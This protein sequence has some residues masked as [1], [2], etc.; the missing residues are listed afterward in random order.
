MKSIPHFILTTCFIFAFQFSFSQNR[1]IGNNE[2]TP[3]C[4]NIDFEFGNFTNWTGAVGYN[5]HSCSLLTIDAAGIMN[6]SLD[7]PVSACQFHTLIDTAY[8]N[9]P[10]GNFP[11]VAPDGGAYSARLGGD[12][13]N[14]Y[15]GIC[16]I[17]YQSWTYSSGEYLERTFFISTTNALLTYEY[18][19]VFHSEPT[20]AGEGPYFEAELFDQFGN[21]IS[22][23][24]DLCV[25][26][27]NSTPPPGFL[28]SQVDTNV[29]YLPWSTNAINLTAFIGQNVTI[30]FTAAG[31]IYGGHFGYAYVDAHCGTT[32][33]TGNIP[34]AGDTGTLAA[35]FLSGATYVWSGP[36]IIGSNTTQTIHVISPGT[37]TVTIHPANGCDFTLSITVTSATTLSFTA[38][39]T[40]PSC[41]S[42]NDGIIN[43]T[44]TGGSPA[45]TYNI[46][47]AA[48]NLSGNSYI[49]LPQDTYYVC[50]TD[51][52]GCT[53][54]DSVVVPPYSLSVPV[55][56]NSS[57]IFF[58]TNTV[59]GE[60]SFNLRFSPAANSHLYIYDALGRQISETTVLSKKTLIESGH[61]LPAGIY[62]YLLNTDK[63]IIAR[64]KAIIE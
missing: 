26:S 22:S 14:L 45:Y 52:N 55:I 21:A 33:I 56:N 20:S 54:C 29:F 6:G 15:E 47:P 12:H 49:N 28:V 30:R 27:I 46:S 23:C 43:F 5:T 11:G 59:T 57:A 37:Y 18:A 38:S 13:I 31:C 10:Y 63:N 62:F 19:V 53:K 42:C 50:V 25:E 40:P 36:G 64:G 3:P 35:P 17:P 60:T 8:G 48:G 9:D 44:T 16:N 41:V 51:A 4:D 39:G 58:T 61:S 2:A 7:N 24:F 32:V 34:C 1:N